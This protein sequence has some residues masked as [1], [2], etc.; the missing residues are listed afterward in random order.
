MSDVTSPA[1][2]TDASPLV[3]VVVRTLGRASLQVAADSVAAQSWPAIELVVVDAAGQGLQAPDC[4]RFP[5]R[6]CGA[7]G[8]L[9]RAAAANAGLRAA[10][11]RFVIL[12]DDD[13]WLYPGHVAKLAAALA[14]ERVGRAAYSG[15][16]AI[17]LDVD[18]TRARQVW[19]DPFD[20]LRLLYENFIPIHAMAFARS[21]VDEGCQF[22]ETLD[23]LE[24]WD[25]W[26]QVAA[27]TALRHLPG[28]TAA[29]RT[30]GASGVH[31]PNSKAARRAAETIVNRWAGRCPAVQV[32]RLLGEL[33]HRELH[34]FRDLRSQLAGTEEAWRLER[35]DR[36]VRE[37]EFEGE[38]AGW[39]TDRRL[40]E[41]ERDGWHRQAVE[42]QAGREAA[43]RHARALEARIAE[44]LGSISWRLTAPLRW[45]HGRVAGVGGARRRS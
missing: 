25:F 38:R 3:S 14:D 44:L 17:G 32:A 10:Q 36:R 2:T 7:G 28:I 40:L 18:G 33:H 1:P 27:R 39:R 42:Q 23:V 11:G 41:G 30:P 13:D 19:D 4:G 15:V 43:E 6:V 9:A 5:V 35:E 45:L 24:D 8:R 21:L 16:E 29:Y 31:D 37:V 20:P 12:L 26:L 34:A 22:D